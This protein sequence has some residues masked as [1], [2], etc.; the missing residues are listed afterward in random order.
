MGRATQG[1]KAKIVQELKEQ[2][3]PLTVL[4][5]VLDLPKSTYYFELQK[6]RC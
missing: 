5:K 2:G 1:E 3:Y 4:L 6:N